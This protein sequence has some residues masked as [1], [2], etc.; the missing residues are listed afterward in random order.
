MSVMAQIKELSPTEKLQ[1]VFDIWDDLTQNNE[2][3]PMPDWH[4]DE[5]D[6]LKKRY[7]HEPQAGDSWQE[8]RKRALAAL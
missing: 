3:I 7:A 8:V 5:L 4:R 1:L 2:S 6:A